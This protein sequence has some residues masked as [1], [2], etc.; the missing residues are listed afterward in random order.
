MTATKL[1]TTETIETSVIASLEGEIETRRIDIELL[2][3]AISTLEA[4]KIRP[5]DPKA[6]SAFA[7]LVEM[8]G[9][10]PENLEQ[11]QIYLAKIQAAK[12]SLKLAVELYQQ[13]Q[14]QL[15]ALKP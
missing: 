3:E 13:K 4:K 8:V 10:A 11:Q 15:K 12:L 2:R 6:D 1:Q 9:A 5:I 14:L 7:L